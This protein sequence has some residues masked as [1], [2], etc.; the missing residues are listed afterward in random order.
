MKKIVYVDMDNVLA[1]FPTGLDWYDE[2]TIARYVK[3]YDDIPGIFSKMKPVPGSIESF[4]LLAKHYDMYILSTSPW[5]NPSAWSDKLLWVKQ[6][7]GDVAYKRLILSH[8]KN[9][10]NG[11]YLIDDRTKNGA[12]E[13]G[14]ELILFKSEQFPDWA[15]VVDYLLPGGKSR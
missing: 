1:D 7:L 2:A 5:D 12:A 3:H 4:R 13:F 6:Y 11:D 15:H 14:G 10:N 8:H 9:L